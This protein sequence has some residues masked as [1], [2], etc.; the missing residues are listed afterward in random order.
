[1]AQ[2]HQINKDTQIEDRQKAFFERAR[3]GVLQYLHDQGGILNM[4]KMHDYSLNK[5]LIQ[6]QGFSQMMETFVNDGLVEFDQS[7]YDVTITEIGK[8]FIG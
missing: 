5:Y 3:K 4:S 7:T 2:E 8:K 6:H 1:M